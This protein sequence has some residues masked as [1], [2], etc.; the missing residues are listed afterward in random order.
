[1]PSFLTVNTGLPQKSTSQSSTVYAQ[2]PVDI[3]HISNYTVFGLNN[4]VLETNVTVV[5]GSAGVQNSSP[6]MALPANAEINIGSNSKFLDP[7][8]AVAGDSIIIGTGTTV[9]N[10]FYNEI[11]NSGSILG[12][13]NTPLQLPLVQSLPSFPRSTPGTTTVSVAA[14]AS[15]TL[16]AGLYGSISVGQGELSNLQEASTM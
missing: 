2:S 16:Q 15:Q 13:Q 12:T 3:R 10:V 4:I 8:S 6:N 5:N 11:K 9:Q 7:T 1:M 14:G